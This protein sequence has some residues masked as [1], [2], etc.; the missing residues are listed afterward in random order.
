MRF[1]IRETD[2]ILGHCRRRKIRC[3]PAPGDP[4]SRC[5]NCIRLK[6]ECN[7]YPVDQQPAPEPRRRGSKVQS[8]TGRNSESS[9]PSNSSGQLPELPPTLP[10]PHLSMPPIQDLGGP[11]MKKSRTESF[12]PENKGALIFPVFHPDS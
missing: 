12:S 11:Q 4:Q 3:I 9:S 2:P 6:K 7:F 5:S 1:L 8:G 10:Y